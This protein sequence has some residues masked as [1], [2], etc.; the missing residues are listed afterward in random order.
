MKRVAVSLLAAACAIPVFCGTMALASPQFSIEE[1]SPAGAPF[2]TVMRNLTKL[3]LKSEQKSR[4]ATVMKENRPEIRPEVDTLIEA[5]K[6]LFNAIHQDTFDEKLVRDSAKAVAAAEEQL[7]VSRAKAVSQIRAVLSEDQKQ[8][9]SGLKN[10]IE[11]RIEHRIEKL[12]TLL[13]D[14][15]DANAQS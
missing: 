9:L 7:A 6:Q 3:D 14:W 1:L 4:I 2:L 15:I 10:E 5:H 12:R 13:D 8:Q 11:G